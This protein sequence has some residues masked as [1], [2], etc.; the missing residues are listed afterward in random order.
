MESQ[1]TIKKVVSLEGKG[2]HTGKEVKLE[3]LPAPLNSGIF[4]V[5]KDINPEVMIKA[6]AY[7]VLPS[8]KFPRRTSVGRDGF[9]NNSS[10]FFYHKNLL[11]FKI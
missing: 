11:Y 2:L 4:F 5:R 8:E 9:I 3:L 6:D 1:R 10:S 7:S